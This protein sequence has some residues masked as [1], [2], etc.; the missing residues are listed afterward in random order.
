MEKIQRIYVQ[1]SVREAL[2]QWN[3]LI[4]PQLKKG[5]EA[6]LWR[7]RRRQWIGS[8]VVS[9]IENEDVTLEMPKG[10]SVFRSTALRQYYR[11]LSTSVQDKTT[12]SPAAVPPSHSSRPILLSPPPSPSDPIP[13]VDS[14][15]LA[16]VIVCMNDGV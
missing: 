9:A 1:R 2:A 11:P 3:G 6:I 12:S 8:Y 15:L 16:P 4:P 13:T 7:M 10:L 14:D 5:D